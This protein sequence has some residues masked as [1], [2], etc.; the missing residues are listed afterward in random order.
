MFQVSTLDFLK[1]PQT[2]EGKVDF[3]KDF[4]GKQAS[5]TVSGQ[6]EAETFA[7]AF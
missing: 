3:S 1:M 7:T 2:E 5:L 6:L 4:F